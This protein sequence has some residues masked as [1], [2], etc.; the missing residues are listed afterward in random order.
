MAPA[1]IVIVG[2]GFGGLNV[3]K[4]LK[5]TDLKILLLDKTNHHLFQPLLY[6]VASAALSPSNIASPL[7]AILSNQ[8]NVFVEMADIVSI[9]KL[10]K[11]IAASN[12]EIFSYDF[13]ILSVGASHS[14]FGHDDWEAFAPGL[15]TIRDA[16]RIR[17]RI[18]LGFERAEKSQTPA[19]AA[20]NL[21]FVIIGAGPTGVE[22]AGAIAEIARTSLFNNFRRIKPENSEIFL[23][24]GLSQVLPSYPQKLSER[25][26][27]DLEKMGVTVMTNTRVTNI[28]QEG[29][30]IGEK[31]IP[32]YN[33]IWAA[34]N[35]AAPL[36]KTLDVPL[37]KQGRAFVEAD[38]TLP[39]YPEIFVIGD[40]AHVLGENGIPLPGVAQVAMQQAAYVTKILACKIP[41]NKRKPFKYWDKGTMA[42]IGRAKAVVW[43]GKLQFGGLMAWFAWSFLHIFYLISFRN[44]VLVM[45]Q[46]VMWYLTGQR[47][48]RLITRA[49]D[50]NTQFDDYHRYQH[51]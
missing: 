45:F 1:K 47:N 51:K 30:Y 16:V 26:K 35:Q 28:T 3:A 6:Q 29:I 37:D 48:V 13:L 14:Y 44:R 24:E 8:K 11:Q 23:I 5:N 33:V 41:T 38:L 4:G 12:G 19:E 7:R 18:L 39:G 27:K 20:K 49:I 21:C 15:K 32:T 34:G 36:L 43:T 9:D 25:A 46:W 2:G 50:D 17:E 10:K 22:M 31:F 42:T 40:A